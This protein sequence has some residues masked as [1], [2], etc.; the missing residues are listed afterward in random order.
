MEV[1][2]LGIYSTKHQAIFSHHNEFMHVHGKMINKDKPQ[3][4]H[5]EK[6]SLADGCTLSLP[7]HDK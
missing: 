2:L 5:V 7:A 1:Q 6:I 4:F 3:G